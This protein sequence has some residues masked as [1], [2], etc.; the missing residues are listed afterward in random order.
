MAFAATAAGRQQAE[1]LS[2]ILP[3]L[4]AGSPVSTLEAVR[5]FCLRFCHSS[6]TP[7]FLVLKNA[8]PC[9]GQYAVTYDV[10]HSWT[11]PG[12]LSALC[13]APVGRH[14]ILSLCVSY[15]PL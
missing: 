12:Q 4:E 3:Y 7:A 11:L 10:L 2:Y 6:C 8:L 5:A 1:A 9:S 13:C 14:P 15:R